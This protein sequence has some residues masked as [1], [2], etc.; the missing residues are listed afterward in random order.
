MLIAGLVAFWNWDWF[1]PLVDSRVSAVIGRSVHMGHLHLSL[2]RITRVTADDITIDNPPGWAG[3]PFA[4]VERLSIEIN[5]FDYIRNRQLVVPLIDVQT[6]RANLVQ[7]PD[8]RNNYELKLAGGSSGSSSPRIGDLRIKDSH[9]QAE[10]AKLKSNLGIDIET[11]GEGDQAQ[12]VADAHGTYAAA[13][14]QAH[15]T[16]GALL[17]LRDK[18]RPWPIQLQLRNGQTTLSVA[19]TLQEPL[20]LKGANIKLEVAGQD[21]A[22]LT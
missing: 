17:S 21:M 20:Q 5:I 3:R 10:L 12:I 2:G 4:T 13:P 6:A 9:I 15:M 22:Q 16:G 19:G 1:I 11:Q 7:T 14:I 8:G 18:N